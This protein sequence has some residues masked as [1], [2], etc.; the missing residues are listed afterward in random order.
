MPPVSVI[1]PPARLAV[2]TQ[3]FVDPARE[4]HLRELVRL[5]G[6]APRSVQQEVEVLVVADLLSERRSGNRR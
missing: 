5:T 2:L 4:V 6:L 1:G 3:T